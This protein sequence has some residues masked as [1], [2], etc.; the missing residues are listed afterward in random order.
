MAKWELECM[1]SIDYEGGER[2]MRHESKSISS[3]NADSGQLQ[4]RTIHNTTEPRKPSHHSKAPA[5]VA[6]DDG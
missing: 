1:V 6:F 3:S 5:P 4:T 2:S